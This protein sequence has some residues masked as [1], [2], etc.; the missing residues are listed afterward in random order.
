MAPLRS[1][2]PTLGT[3]LI[4][5]SGFF[6]K[7][8]DVDLESM[9]EGIEFVRPL[10]NNLTGNAFTKPRPCA[11]GVECTNDWQTRYLRSQTHSHYASGSCAIGPDSDPMAVLDSKFRVAGVR[12]LVLSMDRLSGATWSSA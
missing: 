5:I 6:Q 1:N 10:F 3:C 2:Q 7:G 9:A 11:A 12:N 8:D 4:S